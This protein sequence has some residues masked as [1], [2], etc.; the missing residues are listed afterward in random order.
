M[1]TMCKYDQNVANGVE[2][3]DQ[4]IKTPLLTLGSSNGEEMLGKG[5][6]FGPN[7]LKITWMGSSKEGE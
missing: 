4:N 1:K 7:P 5:F 3:K 6:F 2:N